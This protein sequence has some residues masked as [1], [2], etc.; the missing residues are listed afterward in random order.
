MNN[1]SNKLIKLNLIKNNDKSA[2]TKN[3]NISSNKIK[4]FLNWSNKIKLEE[5]LKLTLDWYQ[6]YFDNKKTSYINTVTQ[7]KNYLYTK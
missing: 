5:T 1:L 3:L 4:K 7:I 6:K 2:E